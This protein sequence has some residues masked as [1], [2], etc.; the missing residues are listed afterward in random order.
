MLA[1]CAGACHRLFRKECLSSVL[2]GFHETLSLEVGVESHRGSN[3]F[4]LL[5]RAH[6]PNSPFWV[7]RLAIENH[8]FPSSGLHSFVIGTHCTERHL[9]RSQ[10]SLI[11]ALL[12][13]PFAIIV[14]LFDRLGSHL[15]GGQNG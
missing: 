4:G 3:L 2:K 10:H 6:L 7:G 8:V 1:V 9:R 13:E 12:L 5:S 11:M 15:E 14:S